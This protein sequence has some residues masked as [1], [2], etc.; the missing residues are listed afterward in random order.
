MFVRL[1]KLI[2]ISAFYIGRLDTPLFAPGVGMIGPMHLDARPIQFRKDLLVHD[3]HRHPYIE[4]LAVIYM[5]KLG[6]GD[7]FGQRAGGQWRLIF[8]MALMPWLRRYRLDD[9]PSYENQDYAE[10]QIDA[11][12]DSDKNSRVVTKGNGDGKD[13]PVGEV[14]QVVDTSKLVDDDD[15]DDELSKTQA[16]LQKATADMDKEEAKRFVEG[17]LFLA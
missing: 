15:D 7:Q 4:R 11:D 6:Y 3:A 13:A 2:M 5:L 8:V 17:L 14:E 10:E 9:G 12:V 16:F 1:V